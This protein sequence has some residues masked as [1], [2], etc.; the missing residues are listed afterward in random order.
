M[1]TRRLTQ[2]TA[3][4]AVA[5]ALAVSASADDLAAI[6][7]EEQGLENSAAPSGDPGSRTFNLKGRQMD[8]LLVPDS[9]NDRIMAFD[10]TTGA[11]VDADFIPSDST[12]LSTPKSAIYKSD[13]LGFLVV[14]QIDDAVQE[15]DLDGSYL[16]IFAPA[17][18]VDNTIMDNCRSVD[19][20]PTTGRLLVSVSAGANADAIAE[21]DQGTGAYLGN[22][23]ANGAGGMDSPWDILF[24]ATEAFVPAG[25]S[26]AVH[27]YDATTGAYIGDLISLDSLPEQIAWASNGNMLIAEWGGTQEGIIEVQLDGTVVGVYYTTE[28]DGPR[29]VFELPSGNLLVTNGSGVHEITR[30]STFIDSK[31]TGISCHQINLALAVVP[32]ELQAF[33]V[34]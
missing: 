13:G 17:G 1:T 11:L 21:F 8:L 32:V 27:R 16:G 3:L 14:D 19:Y 28:I 6:T 22:F 15:Y 12:N 20:H 4:F 33:T 5:A 25:D 26:D 34:E 29:G 23:I 10:A 24:N 7:A 2:I 30:S 31:I 18:G 9:T